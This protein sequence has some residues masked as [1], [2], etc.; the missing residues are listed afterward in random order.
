MMFK[1]PRQ[2]ITLGL[3]I[4]N[5][6]FLKNPAEYFA[7]I[8]YD[9]HEY[10]VKQVSQHKNVDA[11]KDIIQVLGRSDLSAFAKYLRL[12]L[13]L[14]CNIKKKELKIIEDNWEQFLIDF[15]SYNLLYKVDNTINHE[16]YLSIKKQ[17]ERTFSSNWQDS[18]KRVIKW[19]TTET[20]LG[21]EQLFPNGWQ[22]TGLLSSYGYTVGKSGA[23]EGHR[24]KTLSRLVEEDINFAS[25]KS[26]Y[27]NSWGKSNSLERLLKLARTIAV[28]CRNAKGS[29]NDLE[30][31]IT[32]WESDLAFLKEKYFH[33]F[34]NLDNQKWPKT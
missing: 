6:G 17:L 28:L 7:N 31:A 29:P 9:D 11:F 18:L 21:L 1:S 3:Y 10:F 14:K 5:L 34:L 23:T 20:P 2:K 32:E 27:I 25:F 19:P 4:H 12:V 24:R 30:K 22:E 13:P 15:E 33:T 26:S 16:K 8:I